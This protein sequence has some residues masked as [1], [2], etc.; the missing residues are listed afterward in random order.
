MNTPWTNRMKSERPRAE[1]DFYATP[2]GLANDATFWLFAEHSFPHVPLRVLDPGAGTGVWGRAVNREMPSSR[3]VGVDIA[4]PSAGDMGVYDAYHQMDYRDFDDA[5]FHLVIGNPPY[6]LAEAFVRKSL[7]LL[8]S[9]GYIYF[10]LQLNFLGSRGRQVGL[11]A[12]F[13]PQYIYVLT[14]RPSFF[15][16]EGKAK[17]TDANNYAMYLWQ[18]GYQGPTTLKWLY[19][20]Y[21]NLS[22]S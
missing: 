16:V 21:E 6:A 17:S 14:R 9:G 19:W 10:L 1:R 4:L 15:S 5:G 12:E 18:K 13:P 7:D 22:L 11:F 8:P 2:Q 20:E 3:V